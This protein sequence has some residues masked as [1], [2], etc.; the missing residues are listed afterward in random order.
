MVVFLPC[1]WPCGITVDATIGTGELAG[2]FAPPSVLFRPIL[3]RQLGQVLEMLAFTGPPQLGH[4][5]RTT[6]PGSESVVPET[7]DDIFAILDAAI[8]VE[9]MD[10][11]LFFQHEPVIVCPDV[12]HTAQVSALRGDAGSMVMLLLVGLDPRFSIH[13]MPDHLDMVMA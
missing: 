7:P 13:C 1:P 6:T 10:S 9:I 2:H 8:F 4:G 3:I 12:Y 11:V 5:R